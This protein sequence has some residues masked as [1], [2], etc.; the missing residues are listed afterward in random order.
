M[1]VPSYTSDVTSTELST[2]EATT[3]WTAIGT[4]AISVETDYPI[5]SAGC[6][7]KVGWTAATR[8]QIFN[9]GS[10]R[11]SLF[12]AS[13]AA[14]LAWIEYHN[15]SLL[16]SFAN[17]G[18][19]LIIGS[20]TAAYNSWSVA[21]AETIPYAGWHCFAVDPSVDTN[22]DITPTGSPTAVQQYFGAVAKV[23]GSGALK[24]NPFGVDVIR[25]GREMR[26]EFGETAN[27]ATL[28]GAEAVANSVANRWGLLMNREGAFYM[29]GLFVMGTATNAVDYRDSDRVLFI[30]DTPK[31]HSEFNGFEI[32]HASSRVDWTRYTVKALGTAS[33]GRFIVTNNADVN[34]DSCSFI[35][36]DSFAFLGASAA[37][38]CVFLRCNAITAPGSNLSGSQV[39]APTVATNTSAVIWDVATNPAG[40]LDDMAFTKGTNAH[41]A[42][43]FGLNSPT[44]ISLVGQRYT[45]FNAANAQDDSVLHIKRTT[46]EVTINVSGGDTPSYRTDGA[47]VVIQSAVTVTLTGL[48]N[49][50]EGRVYTRDG[51][52]NSDTLLDGAEDITTGSFAFSAEAGVHVNIVIFAV[53][54]L[55]ADIMDYT[56][57]AAA[58]SIPIQQRFD[59][60]YENL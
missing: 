30:L 5:Q 9:S 35:D 34:L 57:P 47:T 26:S 44:S 48:V 58:A 45:G 36:M 19:Q 51:S 24:G 1:T 49:P 54:Y 14:Y 52:G 22:G 59:R 25:I 37:L 3:N 20:G 53:G 56:I 4:G 2:A 7:S 8:G 12:G 23:L 33:R 38:D 28:V 18:I 31:V 6:I 50:T 42:I 29:Q 10:D 60:Q 11:A 15:P 55:P 39:T 21:G 32:R 16:D 46:G 41:H 17:G 40:F 43:E 13:R 27:F